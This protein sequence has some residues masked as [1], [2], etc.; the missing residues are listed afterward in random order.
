[1]SILDFPEVVMEIS[2]AGQLA[3]V[4]GKEY[5]NELWT[6]VPTSAGW[7]YYYDGA[8]KAYRLRQSFLAIQKIINCDDPDQQ[9]AI[10]EETLRSIAAPKETKTVSFKEKVFE[11]LD[12]IEDS[13]QSNRRSLIKFGLPELDGALYPIEP[14]NQIVI[15]ASTGGGKTAL[16][17]Q[18]AL[19]SGVPCVIFSLEMHSRSLIVRMLSSEAN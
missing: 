10:A 16:A 3:E 2:K 19:R 15:A 13:L 8:F 4:G 7:S 1:M 11:A 12:W 18:A 17:C 14:G 5:L 6:S 9:E